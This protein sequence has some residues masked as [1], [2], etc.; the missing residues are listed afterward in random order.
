MAVEWLK[1]E[2]TTPE[3]PEVRRIAR[4]L[5]ID[6]DSAFGKLFKMW[7]YFDR[8]SDDGSLPGMG[9][10]DIDD[11]A[12]VSGFAACAVE[13]GWLKVEDGSVVMPDFVKHCGD[14]AK[15]RAQT[16]R[17]VAKHSS[18]TNAASVSSALAEREGEG[19]G[20]G[21]E[22]FPIPIGPIGADQSPPIAQSGL[23]KHSSKAN[24][25]EFQP[26]DL[27]EVDWEHVKAM[28]DS[29]GKRVPALSAQDR[30][31]WFRYCVIA[32]V[33]FSENWLMSAADDVATAKQ[34]KRTRQAHLVARLQDTAS[35]FGFDTSAF[36]GMTRRIEIPAD[37]WK[38]KILEV[39]K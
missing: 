3:K 9:L 8:H 6:F 36:Q 31:A 29:L 28:A 26:L 25:G 22:E 33:Y 30:R 7:R 5:G 35:E 38:A 18:K 39:R 34:R 11:A 2:H 13:V 12:G 20:E 14:G 19:E 37:V 32:D 23:R 17:R 27:S 10:E 24:A 21:E 4:K 1:V 15:K 16:A